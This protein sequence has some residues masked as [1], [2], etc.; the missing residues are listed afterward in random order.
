MPQCEVW[1]LVTLPLLQEELYSDTGYCK[2]LLKTQTNEQ[3]TTQSQ[4][5]E[6]ADAKTD[7]QH[8]G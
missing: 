2:K 3:A 8:K 7:C 1:L 4:K 6:L 5:R